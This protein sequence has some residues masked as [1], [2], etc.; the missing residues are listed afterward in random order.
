MERRHRGGSQPRQSPGRSERVLGDREEKEK[1]QDES[2]DD[3]DE[4]ENGAGFIRKA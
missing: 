2:A 4:G 3:G 1:E